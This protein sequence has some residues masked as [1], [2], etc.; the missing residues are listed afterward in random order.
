MDFGIF[1]MFTVRENGAQS[2]AFQ[3]FRIGQA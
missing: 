1:T 2:E 3:Y